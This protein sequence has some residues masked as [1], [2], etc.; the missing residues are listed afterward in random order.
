MA[1]NNQMYATINVP[2][3]VPGQSMYLPNKG[4]DGW[5]NPAAFAEPARVNNVK[6][7][8][9]TLFGNAAR[10]VGRGPGPTTWTS[11]SSRLSGLPSGCGCSSAPRRST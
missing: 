9:I 1:S 3:L 11:R 7:V 10:R 2:D 5:F 8:P 6:G 4:V